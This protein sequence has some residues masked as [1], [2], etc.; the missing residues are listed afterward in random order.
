MPVFN[1]RVRQVRGVV[2]RLG[3]LGRRQSE[4][5]LGTPDSLADFVL[6]PILDPANFR[7]ADKPGVATAKL[8][9]QAN[10]V[11]GLHA[12]LNE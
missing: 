10:T 12:R 9:Y 11:V 1:G 5:W 4:G 8:V 3:S 7:I 2:P 6:T